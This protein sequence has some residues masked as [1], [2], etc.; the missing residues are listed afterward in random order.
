MPHVDV[1]GL[2]RILGEQPLLPRQKQHAEQ[3]TGN[4]LT[5][6]LRLSEIALGQ[7]AG[8][9][10]GQQ[11]ENICRKK[12]TDSWEALMERDSGTRGGCEMMQNRQA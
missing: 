10:A 3:H 4:H 12:A 1:Q 7:P 6:S 5:H 11:D 9:V 2:E 8:A